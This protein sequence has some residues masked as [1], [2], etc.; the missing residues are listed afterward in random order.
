VFV[1]P[2]SPCLKLLRS[3]VEIAP[4]IGD[5]SSPLPSAYRTSRS[6]TNLLCR[7]RQTSSA[8]KT[9]RNQA[10]ADRRQNK[11]TANPT[12]KQPEFKQQ[13]AAFVFK[14]LQPPFPLYHEGVTGFSSTSGHRCSDR[15][16]LSS[17]PSA[18]FIVGQSV[19]PNW[20]TVHPHSCASRIVRASVFKSN[21]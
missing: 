3:S 9:L 16:S 19:S 1:E 21:R 17:R 14:R 6:R 20:C 13:L 5:L 15:R 11:I 7:H 8:R 12:L 18:E 2:R 4:Q 10:P